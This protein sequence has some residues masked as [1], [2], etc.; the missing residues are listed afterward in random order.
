MKL[1][2]EQLKKI[3]K[4]YHD[5]W[6]QHDVLFF[7]ED[8]QCFFKENMAKSHANAIKCKFIRSHKAEWVEKNTAQPKEKLSLK[9]V[10]LST[11]G[12]QELR[13]LGIQHKLESL[14]KADLLKDLCKL[15]NTIVDDEANKLDSAENNGETTETPKNSAEN[16]GETTETPK[17]SA[18]NNGETTETPKNSKN[19]E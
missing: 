17:N 19:N 2:S 18:E 3:I 7:T 14:T 11:L 15:Q 4:E 1:K 8:G 16:N 9:E 12:Y 10:D 13:K 5:N 6:P